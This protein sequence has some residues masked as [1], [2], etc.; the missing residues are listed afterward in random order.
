MLLTSGQI[1]VDIVAMLWYA[2][3][4]QDI[5]VD[6]I[7]IQEM[8]EVNNNFQGGIK[9]SVS[10]NVEIRDSAKRNGVKL[11]MVAEAIGM[12]DSAFSRKLRHELEPDERAKVLAAIEKLSTE[13]AE[14]A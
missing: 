2:L 4:K 10:A 9:M 14:V 13:A 3:V 12:T 8:L 1:I 11:W 6:I 7:V 5:L